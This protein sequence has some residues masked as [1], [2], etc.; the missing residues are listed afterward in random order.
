MRRQKYRDESMTGSQKELRGGGLGCDRSTVAWAN[1]TGSVAPGGPPGLGWRECN[2]KTKM[3]SWRSTARV[4][5][6]RGVAKSQ[7]SALLQ[8]LVGGETQNRRNKWDVT[9]TQTTTQETNW[10]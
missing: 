5:V 4:H 2:N 6:W 1:R 7:S 3:S 8:F 9:Q 10:H